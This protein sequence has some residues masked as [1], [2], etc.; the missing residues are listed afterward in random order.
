MSEVNFFTPIVYN[1]P[2][3]TTAQCALEAVDEYFNLGELN[4]YKG[5]HIRIFDP[6]TEHPPSITQ[7]EPVI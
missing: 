5:A 3:K 1:N 7:Q 6:D 4:S 2:Q